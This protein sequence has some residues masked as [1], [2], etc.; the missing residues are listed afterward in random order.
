[1]DKFDEFYKNY[2]RKVAKPRAVKAFKKLSEED[3][4]LAIIDCLTRYKNTEKKYIPHPASYLNA[5][6]FND[7]VIHDE[8]GSNSTANREAVGEIFESEANRAIEAL[9]RSF[10]TEV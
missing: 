10:N 5:E 1:M 9:C 3:K 2:P 7:E 8:A 4:D 6:M